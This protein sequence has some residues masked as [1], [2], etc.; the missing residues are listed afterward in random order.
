M[1]PDLWRGRRV[2]L[3]GHTG[4]KGAW[5][6][7]WLKRAGATVT[8]FALN[9]PTKPNLYEEATIGAGIESVIADIRD[10][11][12]VERAM[13]AANPEVVLHLA[14]QPI[15]R[16]SYDD[17]VGTYST[18]VMGT[19]HLLDAV[20]RCP[21]VRVVVVVTS[22]KC[23]E[24]REWLW[25]YRENEPMGGKDPY[26]NSK[27]CAELVTAAYRSSFFQ[28]GNAPRVATARA[29]NIVGGGDW[30]QDR[31]VP[32]LI[33]A[34][35]SGSPAQIRNPAAIRPWQFVLDALNG[36]LVLAEAL[37]S[38]TAEAGAWNFGPNEGD[39]HSVEWIADRLL[40]A[41][42]NDAAWTRDSEAHV[43]EAVTLKLDSTRS[44]A[45][46]GWRP[47]VPLETAVDWLVE[48]YGGLL[49]GSSAAALMDQQIERFE[50]S[51]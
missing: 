22:D 6:T 42:G 11:A 39:A 41:W 21:A 26:S 46:L 28:S 32:D 15:V 17:P 12:A 50:G 8:G 3:T 23:Y 33:R 20:R 1:T 10:L 9:P 31:L 16:A 36:Y 19:V 45:L 38:G 40:G 29:G 43:P 51:Q 24:N 7:H 49:G 47:R 4:F 35:S 30:A 34:F 27:A 5:L 2:F 25:P 14:A 44:R 48:F 18:N 37:W 13:T